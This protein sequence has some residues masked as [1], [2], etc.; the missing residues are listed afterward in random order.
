MRFKSR[1]CRTIR[2][3]RNARVNYFAVVGAQEAGAG[4]VALQDQK[5]EKLGTLEIDDLIARLLEEIG[6]RRLPGAPA[7]E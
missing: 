7:A 3:A 2:E 5:G 4:T 6:E 1:R